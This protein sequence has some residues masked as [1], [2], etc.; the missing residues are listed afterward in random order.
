M[1]DKRRRFRSLSDSRSGFFDDRDVFGEELATAG[2]CAPYCHAVRGGG[3]V[4]VPLL[5]LLRD[6]AAARARRHTTTIAAWNLF[7]AADLVLAIAFGVTSTEG[8]L[9]QLFA[10]PGSQAM[11]YAPWSFVPTVLVPIWLILPRSS[12]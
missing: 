11:Q 8:S 7:G 4:A 5:W 10:A 12:P 2:A 9:L 3:A 1:A 6:G